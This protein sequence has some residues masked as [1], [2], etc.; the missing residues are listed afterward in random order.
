MKSGHMIE[1]L[2]IIQGE[3]RMR[4]VRGLR[5]TPQPLNKLRYGGQGRDR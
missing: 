5:V 4:I 3:G 2:R 1:A